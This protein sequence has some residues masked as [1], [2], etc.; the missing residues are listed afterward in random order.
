M[1]D[2]TLPMAYNSTKIEDRLCRLNYASWCPTCEKDS[3]RRR[4]RSETNEPC[5]RKHRSEMKTFTPKKYSRNTEYEN[6]DLEYD[7]CSFRPECC[8]IRNNL[9]ELPTT[10][11][12]N[13]CQ[14]TGNLLS[15]VSKSSEWSV[16]F[17][18]RTQKPLD[19]IVRVLESPPAP[20]GDKKSPKADF[21]S[22]SAKLDNFKSHYNV[23]PKQST[24]TRVSPPKNYYHCTTKTVEFSQVGSKLTSPP[25]LSVPQ[26]G[27]AKYK[28]EVKT[29][30]SSPNAQASTYYT[31]YYEK[32]LEKYGKTGFSSPG[33]EHRPYKIVEIKLNDEERPGMSYDTSK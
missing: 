21:K 26:N 25:K 33:R 4:T 11:I 28:S 5:R 27:L 30:A 9:C 16:D 12:S 23:V 1:G 8:R 24:E 29:S 19:N 6:M 17:F 20:M 7:Q 13:N 2:C 18:D 15:N 14:S 3:P 32:T 10:Y 31:N 22:I